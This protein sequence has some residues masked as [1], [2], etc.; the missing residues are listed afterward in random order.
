VGAGVLFALTLPGVVVLLVA[1]AV[2]EQLASRRGRRGMVGRNRRRS[3]SAGGLDVFSSALIP[4]READLEAQ[5]TRQ[6]VADDVE[7][8]GPPRDRID[9]GRGVAYL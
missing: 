1:V 5:R 8:G 3:L 7:Q 6:I 2:I 9:R 4:G